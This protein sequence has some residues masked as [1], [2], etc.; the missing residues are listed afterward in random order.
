MRTRQNSLCVKER[1]KINSE[2]RGLMLKRGRHV[3]A[4]TKIRKRFKKM[5]CGNG[6]TPQW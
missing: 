3:V 1:S 5:T 6:L 4:K 2:F